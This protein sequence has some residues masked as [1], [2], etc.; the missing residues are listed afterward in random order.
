MNTRNKIVSLNHL[1][2]KVSAL[3]KAGKRIVFT[4]GCFDLLHFGHVSYLEAM[5]DGKAVVIVGMNSDSSIKKIKA[6]GRPIQPQAAR[7]RVLAALA[8]VDFVTI[9]SD[10]SPYKLIKAIQPDILIK[11]ADWKGKLVVGEDIVK[12]RGGKVKLVQYVKP[13]STS[14]IIKKILIQ[15][16]A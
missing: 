8:C 4:N 3:R 14:N 7:A 2:K 12:A 5:K 16:A 9:F 6:R 11:G 13:F 15:C 1:K 10:E